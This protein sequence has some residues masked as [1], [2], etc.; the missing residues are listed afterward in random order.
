MAVRAT[1]RSCRA[2]TSS[3]TSSGRCLSR[4]SAGCTGELLLVAVTVESDGACAASSVRIGAH[5]HVVVRL[6][7]EP[8]T[9]P[10]RIIEREPQ[11]WAELD[12]LVAA[13]PRLSCVIAG[14]DGVA[15]AL[16]TEGERPQA[17]A[18]C[19]RDAWPTRLRPP[20]ET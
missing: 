2:C 4:R 17:V 19:I 6:E 20:G 7:A 11:G 16:S 5:E 3:T 18:E 8:E 15:L 12:Q 13:S 10:R 1:R 9:L 14:L